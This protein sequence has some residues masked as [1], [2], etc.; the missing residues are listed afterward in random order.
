MPTPHKHSLP[1]ISGD[2]LIIPVNAPD[3]FRYWDIDWDGRPGL[4]VLD[5]LRGLDRE[6]LIPKYISSAEAYRQGIKIEAPRLPEVKPDKK[7]IFQLQ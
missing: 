3:R 4:S 6:D 5:L 2:T 1:F 7:E